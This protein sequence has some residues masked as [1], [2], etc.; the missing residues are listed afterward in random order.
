FD[1]VDR[2]TSTSSDLNFIPD[3]VVNVYHAIAT[4]K[5]LAT[6]HIFKTCGRI[7]AAGVK[8]NE[9]LCDATHGGVAG[10]KDDDG[11]G[12]W[13]K[14]SIHDG[15]SGFWMLFNMQKEGVM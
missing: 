2:D 14:G 5:N 6:R 4:D 12:N 15:G 8:L 3:N 11:A 7:A 13:V 10:N 1:A 9:K